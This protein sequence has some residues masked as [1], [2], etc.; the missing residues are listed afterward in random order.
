[1]LSMPML[2]DTHLGDEADMMVRDLSIPLGETCPNVDLSS[3]FALV[4]LG[5]PKFMLD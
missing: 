4:L 2:W 1:M 3:D 5:Q